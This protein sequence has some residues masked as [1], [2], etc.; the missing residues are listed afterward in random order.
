MLT[1]HS[2]DFGVS[3]EQNVIVRIAIM[4]ESSII[5]NLTNKKCTSNQ[6]ND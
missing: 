1:M 2:L 5:F 4:I 3:M 6:L